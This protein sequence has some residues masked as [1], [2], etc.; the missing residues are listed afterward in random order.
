MSLYFEETG[1][2]EPLVLLHGNGEDHTYFSGQIPAFSAFYRVIAVDTRGHGKSPR[3]DRPLS[4][5]SFADDLKQF[6]EEKKLCPIHL[7]GFS[8]GANIALTFALRYPQFLKSLILNGAN[9]NPGGIR[10]S[11]QI[12]IE[13]GYRIASRF[14]NKSE[15]AR[16]NAEILGLMVNEPHI[17]PEALRAVSVRTLV[18]TGT[19]DMVKDD[20]TALIAH[21]LPHAVW[22]KIKGNH[23]IAAKKSAEFN[24]AVLD[25]L[26]SCE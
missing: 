4:I 23:F 18:I 1:T 11:T 17:P 16:L 26:H 12:P 21:S 24:R 19:N 5:D 13:W 6:L 7:L 14:Q 25:F 9:L 2:G 22:V 15:K 10:R 20:H 8:D 3:G